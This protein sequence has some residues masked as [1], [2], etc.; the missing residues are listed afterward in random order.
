[1]RSVRRA[2]YV[3][4]GAGLT[5]LATALALKEAEPDALVVVVEK[6]AGPARHQSGRN[7][8][9]IHSGIYYKPGSLKARFSVAGRRRLLAFCDEH[10]IDYEICGKV[11][12]ATDED[13]LPRLAALEKRALANGVDARAL[14]DEELRER[15]PGVRA[16]AALEIP[17]TGI[18]SFPRV[19]ETILRLLLEAGVDVRFGTR[20]TGIHNGGREIVAETTGGDV[21]GRF[22]VNCAGLHADRLARLD[23]VVP[24]ARIVPFRGEYYVLREAKRHL[25]RGL[26]YPVPDPAF[27]FLGVHLTRAIDGSVHAG[28]NAVLSLK[29]EGYRRRDFDLKDA[30]SATTY[31]GFWRLAGRHGLEG[32]RELHR[33]LSKQAFVRS[34]RRLVPELGR[35]DI[36]PAEA[37]VRAQALLPDGRLADDFLI[38]RGT[39]SLHLLNAPSPGATS[40]L[41]IGEAL[42]QQVLEGAAAPDAPL[43]ARSL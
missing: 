21:Q 1:V 23:G 28:P 16:I 5:G 13:E 20:V 14:T 22:L 15:E 12:V 30:L 6:E 27:P 31:R 38:V 7:S 36:E 29:R 11:I 37:G 25:V 42:A 17:G 3:V 26:V 39:R 4:I 33:S 34:L 32:M 24:P 10:G 2:D 9:V 43:L 8:G 18:V 40:S 41:V 19:A 35:D